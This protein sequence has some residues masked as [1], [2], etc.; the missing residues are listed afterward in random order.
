MNDE[1]LDYETVLK[2]AQAMGYAEKNPTADVE[3]ILTLV[4]R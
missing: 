1:G 2:E 3:G 4:E